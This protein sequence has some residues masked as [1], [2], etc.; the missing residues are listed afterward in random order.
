M[1]FQMVILWDVFKN[2][3]ANLLF[4][5]L[6]SFLSTTSTIY[7]HI[8]MDLLPNQDKGLVA[9]C[10]HLLYILKNLSKDPDCDLRPASLK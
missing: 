2:Y 5:I 3:L 6:I 1:N 9:T 7:N 4:D 8:L 10:C